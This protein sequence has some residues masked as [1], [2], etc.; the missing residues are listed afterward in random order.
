MY[1]RGIHTIALDKNVTGYDCTISDEFIDTYIPAAYNGGLFITCVGNILLITILY[2]LIVQEIYKH[3]TFLKSF[4]TRKRNEIKSHKKDK[5]STI[6]CSRED[7]EIETTN[8]IQ[9][10]KNSE[11]EENTQ[12]RGTNAQ[13]GSK[14][15]VNNDKIKMADTHTQL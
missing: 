3:F 10:S 6:S 12:V 5:I 13:F 11:Y 9:S 15:F 4:D 8:H 14:T 1:I 7:L 2:V